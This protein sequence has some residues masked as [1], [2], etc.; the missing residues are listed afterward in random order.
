VVGLLA[1]NQ[2]ADTAV[3]TIQGD[4][5]FS[6][7]N[8]TETVGPLTVTDGTVTTGDQNG[9]LT[10][11][12]LSMTGGTVSAQTPGSKVTVGAGGVT[13]T[14]DAAGTAMIGG[15]GTLDLNAITQTFNVSAGAQPID[16][17]VG[18]NMVNGGL[19]N[20]GSGRLQLMGSDTYDRGTTVTQGSLQVD[21]SLGQ[22]GNVSLAGGTLQGTGMS[23]LLAVRVPRFLLAGKQGHRRRIPSLVDGRA[24]VISVSTPGLQVPQ[25][26]TLTV[27][28]TARARRDNPPRKQHRIA[29]LKQADGNEVLLFQ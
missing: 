2:I 16:L 3:V 9:R 6:L 7:N 13:A 17:A 29:V 22:N 23:T 21:G 24:N 11:G 15:A 10:V 1:G 12:S 19:N 18:V 28:E 25:T 20:T 14:S 4:G 5:L 26:A 8:Q 27:F